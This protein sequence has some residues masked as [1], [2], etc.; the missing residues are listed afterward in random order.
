MMNPNTRRRPK[1]ISLFETTESH[2]I[3]GYFE[4]ETAL[5]YRLSACFVGT[6]SAMLTYG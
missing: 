5:A 3:S 1:P 4:I 2:F 6:N